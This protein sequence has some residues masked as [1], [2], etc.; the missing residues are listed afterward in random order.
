M[1]LVQAKLQT[2]CE[3]SQTWHAREGGEAGDDAIG[4]S[5]G[6][7][8]A[9]KEAGRFGIPY[10]LLRGAKHPQDKWWATSVLSSAFKFAF[11]LSNVMQCTMAQ[12]SLIVG[13]NWLTNP[14]VFD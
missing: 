6:Q 2:D 12:Y 14:P 3:I 1:S 5:L 7:L 13:S 11:S 8:S 9:K 4:S 10:I